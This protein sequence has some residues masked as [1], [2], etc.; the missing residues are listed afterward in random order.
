[1]ERVTPVHQRKVKGVHQPP[2]SISSVA[3]DSRIGLKLFGQ[4][5]P[6]DWVITL[7]NLMVLI[8]ILLGAE[9][10]SAGRE[11]GQGFQSERA[12]IDKCELEGKN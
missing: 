2:L 10:A 6:C 4:I 5:P 12:I 7:F 1:M 3:A 9:G 8:R 11:M